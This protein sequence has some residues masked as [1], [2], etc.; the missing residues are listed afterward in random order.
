VNVAQRADDASVERDTPGRAF[1]GAAGRVLDV[2]ALADG[3]VHAELELFGHRDLDLRDLA[4]RPEHAHAL[5]APLRAGDRELLLA[6][7]LAGLRQVG[8]LRQVTPLAE[9]H[10]DVLLREVDVVRRH[11]DEGL[12][13]RPGPA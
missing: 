5:D 13:A 11:L 3:R 12:R 6:R 7:I 10:L 2:A 8:V 4:G 9:Q 1:E